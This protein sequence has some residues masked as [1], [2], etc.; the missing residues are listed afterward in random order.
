MHLQEMEAGSAWMAG[1]PLGYRTW[2]DPL[3]YPVPLVTWQLKLGQCWKNKCLVNSFCCAND[4][5]G[6][7]ANVS[8]VA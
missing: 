3:L 8:C 5:Q 4:D 7:H 6:T 2:G 1:E